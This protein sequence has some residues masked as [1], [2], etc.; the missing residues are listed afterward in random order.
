MPL[1]LYFELIFGR[2]FLIYLN[3]AMVLIKISRNCKYQGIHQGI[4]IPLLSEKICLNPCH[5]IL[6][7]FTPQTSL[8]IFFEV[9]EDHKGPNA[10]DTNRLEEKRKSS[11]FTENHRNSALEGRKQEIKS[12]GVEN[13]LE[14]FKFYKALLLFKYSYKFAQQMNVCKIRTK[15][16]FIK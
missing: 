12:M 11:S 14:R 4:Y 13:I 6:L 16:S 2:I 1:I 3:I 15:N 7:G 10:N 8:S 9:R 5:I